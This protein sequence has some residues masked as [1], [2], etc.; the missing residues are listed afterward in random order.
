[1]NRLELVRQVAGETGLSPAAVDATVRAAL[2]AVAGALARG[3]AVRLSG[4]GSFAA[5]DRPAHTGRNPRTGESVAVPA[6]RS[7]SFRA[8]TGLRDAVNRKTG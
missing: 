1:M 6:S 5:K 7:V 8:G 3:E 2:E 4:F